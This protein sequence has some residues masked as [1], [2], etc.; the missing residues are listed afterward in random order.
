MFFDFAEIGPQNIYKLLVSSIVPRPIAWVVSQDRQ[1][2]LNAAPFS[3]FNVM[4]GDPPILA[5]GIGNRRPNQPKDSAQ[6]ILETGQFVVNLVDEKLAEAMNITAIDFE[7]EVN[8]LDRAQLETSPSS[9]VAPPRIRDSPAAFECE[10]FQ[11]V[12]IEED[13]S[14]L[15]G[16]V[17]ACHIRDDLV[18]DSG[19]CH[20]ATPD[21]QLV[22]RMHGAGWYVRTRELFQIE[23]ISLAQ[24]Q[25]G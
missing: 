25:A 7:A 5:L 16:R 11:A 14:I 3:F 22:G 19:R 23:R 9:K 2:K 1:G 12:P 21:F 17:L 24:W 10:L 18:T 15:L 13:K 8:E 6:N 20:V 4:S